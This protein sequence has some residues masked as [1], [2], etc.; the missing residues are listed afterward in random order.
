MINVDLLSDT[1]YREQAVEQLDQ[2]LGNSSKFPVKSTQIYGLR[3][4]ARQEPERI[5]DFATHQRQRAQSRYDA[6]NDRRNPRDS[7]LQ[8][9][10]AE[11]DFWTLVDNLCSSGTSNWSLTE[12]RDSH[13]P[14][15]LQNRP[16][17]SRRERRELNE[18]KEK[19]FEQWKK[20]HFPAFFERFCTHCLYCIA[21]AD[22]TDQ[23]SQREQN[24]CQAGGAMQTA[25]QQA[26][27]FE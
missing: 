22:E 17:L 12:E 6:E 4:I 19:W 20:E 7:N 15:D 14:V 1:T 8:S 13:I 23:S 24:D 21:M 9:L 10:Q 16:D 11:I 26:N 27:R 5:G 25:F 3:Q 18:R 2:L